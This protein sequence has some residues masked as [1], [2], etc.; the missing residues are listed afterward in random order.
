MIIWQ[1]WGIIPVFIVFGILLL[2]ESIVNA[3][4]HSS[5][6]F[7]NHN[8]AFF[9]A[10]I[11]SGVVTYYAD[12]LLNKIQKPKIFIDKETG[13]EVEMRSSNKLFFIKMNYMGY[14]LIGFGLIGLVLSFFG[15]EI[16]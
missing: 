7:E 13:E 14:I 6:Y 5:T 10:I 2:I 12:Q 4:F 15:I 8:W 16:I 3:I 9:I 1:G 11:L